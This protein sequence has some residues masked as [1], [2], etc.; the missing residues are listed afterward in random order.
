MD[1]IL[2]AKLKSGHLMRKMALVQSQR[3]RTVFGYSKHR[4]RVIAELCMYTYQ[5]KKRFIKITIYYDPRA[6][7]QKIQAK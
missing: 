4:I 1:S 7:F 3:S 5:R 6:I 2:K